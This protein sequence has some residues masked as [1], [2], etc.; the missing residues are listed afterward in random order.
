[1]ALPI[2]RLD[3]FSGDAITDLMANVALGQ[4]PDASLV[5]I[6]GHTP[7]IPGGSTSVLWELD[8]TIGTTG[9]FPSVPNTYYVSSSSALDV[10]KTIKVTILDANYDVQELGV[11]TNGQIGVPLAIQALRVI[12]MENMSSTATAGNVYIGTEPTPTLGVPA[13]LNT[14]D[15]F[16]QT[17]QI[18]HTANYTVPKGY[19]LLVKEFGGG[20]PTADSV[21][22]NAHT[23]NPSAG[24]FKVRMQIPVYRGH[25]DQNASYFPLPE[26]T[27][28]Y[29]SATAYTNNT[30]AIGHIFGVLLPSKYLAT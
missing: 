28:I 25:E 19:T 12:S 24:A 5:Y 21:L 17:H 11:T 1:M 13:R 16:V 23:A 30:E 6:Y 15:M 27:D 2:E 3:T 4:I 10:G 20:T 29:L 26:K 14:I 7:A 18:S 22:I 8:G 9:I